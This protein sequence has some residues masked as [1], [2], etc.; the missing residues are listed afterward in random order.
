[1]SDLADRAEADIE[2]ELAEALR[3]RKPAGPEATG[4][5]L[6][7]REPVA[8]VTRWC[9]GTECRDEWQR[10]EQQRRWKEWV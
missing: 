3:A 5:C 4:F 7:C 6:Y 8:D 10:Q 2:H 9:P 1:M